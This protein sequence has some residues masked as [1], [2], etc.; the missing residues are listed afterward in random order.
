MPHPQPLYESGH[1]RLVT[2]AS[3]RPGGVALTR[4]A[5][6]I[7]AFTQGS[8]ILDAGCG[9]GSTLALLGEMGF[10]HLGV[11]K[12]AMLLREAAAYGKVMLADIL[13]LPLK[14]GC[15]VGVMCE[16]V[17]SLQLDKPAALREICRVLE[18]G[19][20]LILSDLYLRKG[21]AAPAAGGLAGSCL[22]GALPLAVLQNMLEQCGLKAMHVSDESYY[23]RELAARMILK[24]GSPAAFWRQWSGQDAEPETC[25]CGEAAKNL[26]YLLVVA[27]KL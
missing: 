5:L 13:D 2:G 11:D 12:S 21:E 8:R 26:G 16:C 27:E 18:T 14:D 17:F 23:L 4:K 15:F 3:L 19:G 9:A 10:A 6:E 24:F 22:A 1:L 7:C 20:K 25:L